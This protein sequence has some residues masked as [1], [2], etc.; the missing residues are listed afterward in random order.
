M[1]QTLRSRLNAALLAGKDLS[2]E[3][4]FT[5][6][7]P[8]CLREAIQICE[9]LAE[10]TNVRRLV[11]S[12]THGEY[13]TPLYHLAM[14]FQA[15]MEDAA[16]EYLRAHGLPEL[17]RLCDL[18]LVEPEPPAHPL[19]RIAKMFA[20]YGHEPGV[21]RMAAIVRRFPDSYYLSISF[22]ALGSPEHPH[23]PALVERLRE[24]LPTGFAAV[25]TLDLANTLCRQQRLDAH[26]FDTPAGHRMLESW[27]TDRSPDHSSYAVSA[28]ASLP[29]FG[30]RIR[31]RLA[32]LA[33]DHPDT[34]VQMEAA[35]ASAYRG[36]KVGLKFLARL[37]ADPRTSLAAQQ[38]L[39]E[40]GRTEA[41]PERVHDEDFRAMA[42]MCSWLAHP[43]EC[44]RPPDDIELYDARE[45]FWPPTGDTRQL[46][47]FRYRYAGRD[48]EEERSGVGM[49]G[50][51]TFALFGEA[52]AEMPPEDVYGLHCCWELE[53][54]EDPRAPKKRTAR[55]GR[56]LLGI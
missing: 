34:G 4:K 1:A 20:L 8:L 29:F 21:E 18:A 51:I 24:P 55:A 22:Q 15:E 28:A 44:G 43:N 38:Y 31:N 45:L 47:L 32:A 14:L 23:G 19:T 37:C 41:I 27:L 10:Q 36:G 53:M 26:P 39:E 17:L 52:T 6:S 35:W 48:G 13:S 12:A 49:V 5:D 11:D 7:R 9:L 56:K 33:M 25:L 54:N 40:L 50:S 16:T 3:L 42:E 2:E 30:D 46:W